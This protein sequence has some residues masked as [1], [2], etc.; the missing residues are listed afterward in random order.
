MKFDFIK[1]GKVFFTITLAV[2]LAAIVCFFVRGFNMD[3]EFV[4]GTEL[5]FALDKGTKP[6]ESKITEAVKNV[7]GADLSGVR[8]V[9][10][11][12]FVVRTTLVDK[13]TDYKALN[14][15]IEEKVTELY[16]NASDFS[17]S[18]GS[19]SFKIADVQEDKNPAEDVENAF[20][21]GSFL[22]F[23]VTE[24]D[25]VYTAAYTVDSPVNTLRTQVED[26]VNKL[27]PFADGEEGTRLTGVSSVSAEVSDSL[28]RSAVI[29]TVVAVALMLV[30]IAIRFE[31]RA[32][33]AAVV[34][35]TH[36]IIIM[37]F[38]YSIFNIPVSSTII[39][40]ILTILGYSINATIVIFDRI[41]ENVRRNGGKGDFA[42]NADKGVKSTLMRSLNTTITTLITIGLIYFMG[43]TSIKNFALPLIVGIL[44]GVYSSVCL[45]ANVWAALKKVGKKSA[46]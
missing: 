25:G 32:A 45:S 41:R 11:N 3:I 12:E 42:S 30:Y 16:A 36:D 13:E 18:E 40:T 23:D 19:V 2:L 38:A 28:K 27:Y 7:V 9:N 24:N 22:S 14:E 8:T 39:A 35:L 33:V 46:R 37:L 17:K 1:S 15:A 44:A 26:A 4:G 5:S 29:A 6:D 20:A 34:C 10:G 43:V 31:G 21:D